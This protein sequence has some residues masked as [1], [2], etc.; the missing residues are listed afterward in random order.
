MSQTN[1]AALNSALELLL[2]I[3]ERIPFQ[4]G[5]CDIVCCGFDCMSLKYNMFLI[6]YVIVFIYNMFTS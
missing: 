4:E 2:S 1:T 6:F 3:V 5:I